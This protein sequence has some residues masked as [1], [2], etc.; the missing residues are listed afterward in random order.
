MHATSFKH[1]DNT[2]NQRSKL[3]RIAQLAFDISKG[4]ELHQ[5]QLQT[6]CV[7][8]GVQAGLLHLLRCEHKVYIIHERPLSHIPLM[9]DATQLYKA[10]VNSITK[11]AT[12]ARALFMLHFAEISSLPL[13][14]V[15]FAHQWSGV[16]S[17]PAGPLQQLNSLSAW[18]PAL[19]PP[20]R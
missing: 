16:C 2:C 13:F 20:G 1:K 9:H 12:R 5:T 10:G 17:D 11:N 18:H 8:S 3:Q 4:E 15:M 6:S 7:L 14:K 19:S